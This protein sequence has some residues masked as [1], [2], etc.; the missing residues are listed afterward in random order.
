MNLPTYLFR[1]HVGG[2]AHDDPR[3]SMRTGKSYSFRIVDRI[4]CQ[5]RQTKIQNLDSPIFRDEN[6][7]RLQIAVDDSLLMCRRQ[8]VCDMHSVVESLALRQHA[9][10]QHLAQAFAFQKLGNQKR[11]AVVLADVED[12]KDIGMVQRRNRPRFLF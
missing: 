7:L 5:L 4:L 8:P 6:I 10:V 9:S 12:G 2:R 3:R 1:R 11:S